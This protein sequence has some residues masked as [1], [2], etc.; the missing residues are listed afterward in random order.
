MFI[1]LVLYDYVRFPWITFSIRAKKKYYM[2]HVSRNLIALCRN[3]VC[4]SFLAIPVEYYF[5]IFNER[6]SEKSRNSCPTILGSSKYTLRNRI[7]KEHVCV[8]V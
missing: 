2:K 6:T 8:C 4:V 3:Y 1:L 7:V 5:P